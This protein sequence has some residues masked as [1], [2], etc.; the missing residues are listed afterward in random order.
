M[1]DNIEIIDIEEIYGKKINVSNSKYSI[2]DGQLLKVYNQ[3]K[4]ITLPDGVINIGSLT[5]EL[6]ID[7]KLETNKIFEYKEFEELIIPNSVKTIGNNI[8][9]DCIN[10]KKIVLNDNIAQI[11][12]HAFSISK[13]RE[14]DYETI[15]GK[16]YTTR[17]PQEFV[18]NY[19]N[20]NSLI[21]L[22]DKIINSGSLLFEKGNRPKIKFTLVGPVLTKLEKLKLF[23]KFINN[24]IFNIRY[25][26][27]N[28]KRKTLEALIECINIVNSNI[29]PKVKRDINQKLEHEEL[30][31]EKF[32]DI[33]FTLSNSDLTEE[34]RKELKQELIKLI[35]EAI[36]KLGNNEYDKYKIQDMVFN[37]H[38]NLLTEIEKR[39]LNKILSFNI[40]SKKKTK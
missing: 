36:K 32:K 14:T 5:E 16:T 12:K 40:K 26:D 8:L 18:I 29:V 3:N 4:R 17:L 30:L 28:Q 11:G 19:N 10:L 38:I 33:N 9:E 21:N 1:Q 27:I 15:E 7:D 23:K 6:D 2:K 35:K 24:N 31:K 20:Y 39:E 34:E 13:K 22:I 25:I 37:F